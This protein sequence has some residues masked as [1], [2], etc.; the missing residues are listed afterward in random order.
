MIE[1]V[2]AITE[3]KKNSIKIKLFKRLKNNNHKHK[4]CRSYKIF[5]VTVS[6]LFFVIGY[7]F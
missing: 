1:N 3:N 6:K 2:D 7:N 5:L 4:C